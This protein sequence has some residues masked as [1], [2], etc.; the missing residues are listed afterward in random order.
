M[1]GLYKLQAL[2]TEG[3]VLRTICNETSRF[4]LHVSIAKFCWFKLKKIKKQKLLSQPINKHKRTNHRVNLTKLFT[5]TTKSSSK[6]VYSNNKISLKLQTN[7]ALTTHHCLLLV[8]EVVVDPGRVDETGHVLT[9]LGHDQLDCILKIKFKIL[10][11][12]LDDT[13]SRNGKTFAVLEVSRELL[14][15][16]LYIFLNN[17]MS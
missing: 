11:S 14:K 17:V 7:K 4:S 13:L 1:L 16:L 2:G 8:D 5:L 3:K 15:V 6:W 12:S 9:I 10:V